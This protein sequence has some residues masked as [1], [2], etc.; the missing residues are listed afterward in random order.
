[1]VDNYPVWKK[2][3][4]RYLRVF[5]ATF[6][7][8]LPIDVLIM[9]EVQPEATLFRAALAAGIAAVAKMLRETA[10]GEAVNRNYASKIHKIP[11]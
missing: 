6:L 7:A 4:W 11:V 5:F 9:G 8:A 1:M 3:A 2:V 10:D